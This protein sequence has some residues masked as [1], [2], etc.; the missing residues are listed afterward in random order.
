M[1]GIQFRQDGLGMPSPYVVE[2]K[3][4]SVGVRHASTV[5][6]AQRAIFSQ[7][8]REWSVTASLS[9]RSLTRTSPNP[10]VKG[11]ALFPSTLR[12]R[13]VFRLRLRPSPGL[14]EDTPLTQGA[15]N[16]CRI[17]AGIV[18]RRAY[19]RGSRAQADPSLAFGAHCS[20]AFSAPRP[21][22][23]RTLSSTYF[24]SAAG[25]LDRIDPT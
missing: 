4:S 24:S 7:P 9:D 22:L 12:Q 3:R 25:S 17:Y 8:L 14:W 16:S 15:R 13:G 10:K 19:G 2:N 6:R 21:V 18:Y 1:S 11:S 20:A 5:F 23:T